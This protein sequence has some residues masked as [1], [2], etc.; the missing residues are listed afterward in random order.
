MNGSQSLR[1]THEAT[2]G[3]HVVRVGPAGGRPLVALHGGPGEA[4]DCLRPHLDRLAS[5]HRQVVYYDQRGGGRSTLAHGAHPVGWE[6]HVADIELV[7]RH[8]DQDRIDLLGFSWG[9]L[10]ALLH[11]LEH[12]DHV[13]RLVLVSPAPTRSDTGEAMKHELRA[14]AARPEVDAL[15]QRLEPIACDERDP[16]A[17][18]RARFALK[19]APF[20]ADPER[21]LAVTPVET[22]KDV[23]DA[24]ARSLATF[25]LRPRL[26]SLRSVP[27]L[28]VR[29]AQ[30]PMPEETTAE[31]AALLGA[32]LLVL[33][34]CG[35]AP[36]VEAADAFFAAADAFLDG[37]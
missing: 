37:T 27:T 16:E 31:T 36:F 29:G 33:D 35:H 2:G 32:K 21:A 1:S 34:R 24:V 15:R 9:G 30:D 22:R 3:L 17:A 28:V 5:S 20:F 4:H 12:P 11:A 8:L 10:L 25:D 7:R 23:A 13:A 14:A 6:G 19:I 18:R 26:E